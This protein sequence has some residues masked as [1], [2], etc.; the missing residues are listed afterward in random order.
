MIPLLQNDYYKYVQMFRG[1]YLKGA[2]L[3]RSLLNDPV[4]R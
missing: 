1:N 2:S 4:T 3:L